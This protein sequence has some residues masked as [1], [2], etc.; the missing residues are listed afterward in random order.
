M[1]FQVGETRLLANDRLE[2]SP[3]LPDVGRL[4]DVTEFP[5]SV[6]FWRGSEETLSRHRNPLFDRQLGVT[7]RKSVVMD[8]LHAIFLGV[9]LVFCRVAIWALIECGAYGHCG[10]RHEGLVASVLVLR[11]ALMSFYPRHE[12]ENQ[13]ALTRVADLTLSMLGTPSN[14][15]L[16]T[17]GAETWGVVF[18]INFRTS[19]E[20]SNVT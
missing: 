19:A 3:G 20:T 6:I 13:E 1:F 15:T 7:P 12:K 9:L 5:L 17:K 18:F 11:S 4:E 14:H 10:T 16:K 2:P 8:A